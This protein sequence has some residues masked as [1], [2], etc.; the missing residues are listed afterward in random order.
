[1]PTTTLTTRKKTGGK[2]T[3]EKKDMY[4]WL[5]EPRGQHTNKVLAEMPGVDVEGDRVLC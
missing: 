2:K 4:V 3:P 1:M 5:I